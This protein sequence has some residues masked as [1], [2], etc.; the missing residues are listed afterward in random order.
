MAGLLQYPTRGCIR[1]ARDG[2]RNVWNRLKQLW[3]AKPTEAGS[4]AAGALG[5]PVEPPLSEP[6]PPLV[7][8]PLASSLRDYD[9][10]LADV[11]P[12]A[13]LPALR[14]LLVAAPNDP[15]LLA[16]S[17]DALG[18][19]GEADLAAAFSEAATT[20]RLEVF[21]QLAAAFTELAD[22]ELSLAFSN[23]AL[24]VSPRDPEAA[25]TQAQSLA[26]L[27]HHAEVLERAPR[28]LARMPTD[29]ARFE[30]LARRFAMS[31][32]M[33]GDLER[34]REVE[35]VI[36][37]SAP[38]LADAAARL[39]RHGD[40]QEH[41]D[42]RQHILFTLYGAVL[43]DD[44][45]DGERVE[46]DRL[47]RW[48][49]AVA[50]LVA[51]GDAGPSEIRPAWISPRGEVVARWLSALLPDKP[52]PI[53]LS[54]RLPDQPMVV[55]IIDD[56]ELAQLWEQRAFME[57]PTVVFQLLK[58]PTEVGSPMA[59]IIGVLR[60]GLVL[61]FEPLEVERVVDRM[62]PRQLAQQLRESS[63]LPDRGH[64]EAFL[65]WVSARRG[66]LLLDRAPAPWQRPP[67]EP[68]G[69]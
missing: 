26:A 33:L 19:I 45:E 59:D 32:L 1:V 48:V 41:E 67:L 23:A 12:A 36:G 25:L 69:L 37:A 47:G 24:A 20:P 21:H 43:L 35:P 49:T 51:P 55:V 13:S 22:A 28:H 57:H 2:S 9:V 18:A 29:D 46:A 44:A 54:S 65:T 50:S 66:D 34:F 17:A 68:D 62:S 7:I 31:A 10:L 40:V 56:E 39:E 16:R 53:P 8:D 11:G 63:G 64:L 15:R 5:V 4:G 58:D 60:S 6:P 38:W 52:N 30:P 3:N 42:L 14:E 27:G 61:P